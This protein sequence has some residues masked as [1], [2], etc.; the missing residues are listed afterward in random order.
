MTNLEKVNDFLT[1]SK[2]FYII[3][4]DGNKPKARP[5][6]FKM[7]EDNK[8]FFGVGTFKDVYKQLQENPNIEIV[9]T[10]ENGTWLRYD[11]KAKFVEDEALEN[12]CIDM[13][14]PI[15]KMYR[16]NN[17]RMGMFYIEDGHVE[18]K[19]V[20]KEVDKFEL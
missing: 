12:K 17:W 8:L 13:L 19:A 7:V 14:G 2:V 3:T 10:K 4:V 5:I 16:D 9:A 11:G 6:S 20:I 18:I 1:E 15:G